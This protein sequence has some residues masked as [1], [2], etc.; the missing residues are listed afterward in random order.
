[1]WTAFTPGWL[2]IGLRGY[3]APGTPSGS[4]SA[5]PRSPCGARYRFSPTFCEPSGS[6]APLTTSAPATVTHRAA[7]AP[8][9]A[10]AAYRNGVSGCQA[11]ASWGGQDRARIRRRP[12][13]PAPDVQPRAS[14]ASRRRRASSW[15]TSS[16]VSPMPGLVVLPVT[17]TRMGWATLPMP[18][19]ARSLT[20]LTTPS[21][22]ATVHSGRAAS[23]RRA[24]ARAAP[25][26]SAG[27]VL[28]GGLLVQGDAAAEVGHGHGGH[29]LQRLGALA[30]GAT[31]KAPGARRPRAGRGPS[32]PGRAA[33]RSAMSAAG[34]GFRY[35][36]LS[37]SSFSGFHTPE[38]LPTSLKSNHSTICSREMTSSL[39]WLQPRRMTKLSSASGR[40]PLALVQ[41]HV[42]LGVL[43]LGELLAVRPEDERQVGE[44]R[45]LPPQRL[46]EHQL[47]EGGVDVLL[48]A[49]HQGDVHQVVVDDA[50]VV[51]ERDAVRAHHD[52]VIQVRVRLGDVAQHLVVEGDGALAARAS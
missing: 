37:H 2:T 51:V 25:S 50:A 52:P 28:G 30:E 45:R 33:S 35:C 16:S 14:A 7:T 9:R 31:T 15:P 6:C 38:V 21:S 11:L 29:L 3:A 24:P 13:L 44:V 17:A 36:W 42:R 18:T 46:V 8:P 10:G 19:P 22:A 12:P 1:M 41:H 43:A 47:R 32:P 34:S 5:S 20:V 39:P 48:A 27:E 49:R 26:E 4:T 40:M 23:A